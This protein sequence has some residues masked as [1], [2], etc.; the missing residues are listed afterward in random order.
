MKRPG[1]LVLVLVVSSIACG[2]ASASG[3]SAPA[4]SPVQRPSPAAPSLASAAPSEAPAETAAAPDTESEG[5]DGADEESGCQGAKCIA[6]CETT[7]L[8]TD[9]V[10][11]GDA[12]RTGTDVKEDAAR[13]S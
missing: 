12:L 7:G 2:G 10:E 9:C 5:A 1:P 8:P 13:A 3:S 6:R 11:A 4:S